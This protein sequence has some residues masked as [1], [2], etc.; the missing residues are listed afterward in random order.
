MGSSIGANEME[1]QSAE[2]KVNF[3]HKIKIAVKEAEETRYWLMLCEN[4]D[5]YPKPVGLPEKLEVLAKII[6]P[7]I[8]TA[9]KK[10]PISYFLI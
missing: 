10:S 9:T 6:G 5:N 2:S 8:S 4:A 1:A 7:I 3:I